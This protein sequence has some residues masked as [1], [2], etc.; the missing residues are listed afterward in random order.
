[1]VGMSKHARM[2]IRY[3]ASCDTQRNGKLVA[4]GFIVSVLALLAWAVKLG[5]WLLMQCALLSYGGAHDQPNQLD[6]FC[7]S[8]CLL[9]VRLTWSPMV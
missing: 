6:V 1:M 2:H 9:Q 7:S 5:T 3:V 4:A 8:A